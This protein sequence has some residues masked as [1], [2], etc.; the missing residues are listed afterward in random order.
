[1]IFLDSLI[2]CEGRRRR[3]GKKKRVWGKILERGAEK[4]TAVM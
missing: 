4:N 3:P 1:L 2:F